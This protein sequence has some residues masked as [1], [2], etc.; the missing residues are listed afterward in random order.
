ML[1]CLAGEVSRDNDYIK[2]TSNVH[3]DQYNS[4]G[5]TIKWREDGYGELGNC[6]FRW[7]FIAGVGNIAIVDW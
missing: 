6:L 2:D 1:K 5:F 4:G 3:I 7:L